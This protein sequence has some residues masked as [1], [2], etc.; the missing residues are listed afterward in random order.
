M[1][2]H[3]GRDPLPGKD[4]QG[5]HIDMALLDAQVAW[6][7]NQASNYLVSGRVPRR[8][9]MPTPT[10]FLMKPFKAKDGIY[11]ALGVGND[12]SG[13]SSAGSPK[14]NISWMT[15][16]TPPNPNE[17]KIAKKLVPFSRKS[18]PGGVRG[19]A[20]APRRSGDSRGSH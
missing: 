17:W 19:V 11:V 1:L 9:E 14:S 18:P 7:A 10:S 3:P 15:P 12:I 20:P 4:R 13:R 2:G 5:Q 6:L 16:S 8:M